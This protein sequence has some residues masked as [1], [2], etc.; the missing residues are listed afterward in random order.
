MLFICRWSAACNLSRA[1]LG[2]GL[3]LAKDTK[4]YSRGRS[5]PQQVMM[6]CS[7]PVHVL[8]TRYCRDPRRGTYEYIGGSSTGSP[9]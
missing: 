8:E 5:H 1:E 4:I 2:S 9:P 6:I 7:R 3:K